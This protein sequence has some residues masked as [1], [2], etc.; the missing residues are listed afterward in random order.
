MKSQIHNYFISL[1]V[2]N[3]ALFCLPVSQLAIRLSCAGATT[4]DFLYNK[5]GI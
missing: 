5:E 3:S 4:P 1:K 2:L